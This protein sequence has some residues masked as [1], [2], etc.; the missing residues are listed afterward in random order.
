MFE[1]RYTITPAL[2]ET[3]KQA[4]LLV[5]R[6]NQRAVP[7]VRLAALYA[8]AL[9]T[10]T[11]A[12]TTIE[13]NPLP[14]TEVKRLLKSQPAHLRESER[15]VLNYNDT[16]RWLH[17]HTSTT[18]DSALLQRIHRGVM[19]GLLPDHQVGA[20]RKQP[21]VIYEP[22]SGETRYLPPDWQDVPALMDG[23][24]AWAQANRATLDPLILAGLFHKQFV[25][26]HPF[27]DGNGRSARLATK[28][29]LAGLGLNTF[30]LL[31]FENYYNRNVRRYFDAV[32]VRGNYYDI[33]SGLEFTPWLQYFADGVLDELL[34]LEKTLAEHAASPDTQLAAH[35]RAILDWINTHGFIT[36]RDYSRLTE[37]AKSTRALDFRKL[38]GLGLI[39]RRGQGRRVHYVRREA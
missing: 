10:A 37:R 2:L 5:H 3:I 4:T 23:L 16:L 13:G 30:R 39:E 28:I 22:A 25:I 38:I 36:D 32:G 7:A 19:A 1:P 8:E 17:D 27:M 29:L 21:V 12:S 26:V 31:S 33:A 35:H 9:A 24:V 34:R 18:F 20:W 11:W 15:E 14:I 6:L